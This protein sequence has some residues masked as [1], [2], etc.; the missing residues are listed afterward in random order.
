MSRTKNQ[1]N[2]Y[3]LCAAARCE[4]RYQTAHWP[5]EERREALREAR[6]A[7]LASHDPSQPLPW[8]LP[9]ASDQPKSIRAAG[10]Q[11]ERFR[12]MCAS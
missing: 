10:R 4:L 3:A 12:D 8:Y 7:W 5:S 1:E 11:R 2:H 9:S 6:A